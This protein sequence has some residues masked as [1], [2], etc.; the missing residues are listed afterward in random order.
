MEQKVIS[1]RPARVFAMQLLYSMEITAGTAGEC[2]PG[3]LES[4][5][6]EKD[7]QAF[8]MSLVDLVQE[9]RAEIDEI[10][11]SSSKAWTIE[12]M[13]LVDLSILRSSLAEIMFKDTPVKVIMT[14][15]M[16][17]AKKYSTEDSSSFING[18]LNNYAESQGMFGSSSDK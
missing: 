1:K 17:I 5:P 14:E 6:I 12:R 11:S 15:A 4:Q 9:H 16:Q 7:M 10:I 8:G 18:I 3:V 2:L 13:A